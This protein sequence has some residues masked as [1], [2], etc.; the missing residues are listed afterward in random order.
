MESS[1]DNSPEAQDVFLES[2]HV[3]NE[4]PF[5]FKLTYEKTQKEEKSREQHVNDIS[6][7]CLKQSKQAVARECSA[8]F[9]RSSEHFILAIES[10]KSVD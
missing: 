7:K 8:T 2:R 3:V 9:C 1:Q 4:M 5:D 10:R 6:E